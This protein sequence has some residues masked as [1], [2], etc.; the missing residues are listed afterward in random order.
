MSV[1]QKRNYA[2][3]SYYMSTVGNIDGVYGTNTVSAVRSFQTRHRQ[4]LTSDGVT[5]SSTWNEMGR[6][7][8]YPS[9]SSPNF[10]YQ[11]PG[12]TTYRTNYSFFPNGGGGTNCH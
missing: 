2:K 10:Y 1:T 3:C 7:T 4:G 11:H 12:S 9:P 5:G 6:Y 8:V